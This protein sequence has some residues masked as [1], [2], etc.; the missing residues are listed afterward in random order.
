M[1]FRFF[2]LVLLGLLGVSEVHAAS[3]GSI[4]SN[5]R[6]G[7]GASRLAVDT[8][9]QHAPGWSLVT[10]YEVNPYISGEL[11]YLT[12]NGDS[13]SVAK[14]TTGGTEVSTVSNHYWNL[15]ALG[16]WPFND[17]Y[18]AI[19]RV[20]MLS[21]SG[22]SVITQG[23]TVTRSKISGNELFYGVGG[24]Y[25]IGNGSLRLEYQR[26]SLFQH[27]VT[28]IGFSAVWKLRK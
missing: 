25:T 14:A 8:G 28:S 6:L 16:A 9:G 18:S 22:D 11:S 15:S 4:V 21:F 12:T 27:T 10:G 7:W 24:A 13:F 26:S 20:G 23:S 1:R 5:V 17:T 2:V 19:V 3:V